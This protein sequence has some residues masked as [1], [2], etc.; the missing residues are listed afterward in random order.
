MKK[1]IYIITIAIVFTSCKKEQPK[2]EWPDDPMP[3]YEV[4]F[5]KPKNDAI[6]AF[7]KAVKE[8]NSIYHNKTEG[9]SA[10]LRSIVSGKKAGQY[11]WVE[12]PMSFEYVDNK[13]EIEGRM[14]SWNNNIMPHLDEMTDSNYLRVL[15]PLSYSKDG[16]TSPSKITNVTEYKIKKGWGNN[17][18][19][20]DI[21]NK[22]LQVDKVSNYPLS[23]TLLRPLAN[24]GE[25]IGYVFVS[26]HEN[27]ASFDNSFKDYNYNQEIDK[28]YGKE[29]RIRMWKT[30][31]ELQDNEG[32]W[33]SELVE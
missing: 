14:E 5:L 1:I 32:S 11:I 18:K 25:D 4:I 26:N 29:E 12:G 31:R 8:H 10:Y 15:T 13:K 33:V 6:E 16:N 7:Q 2:I 30:L 22:L 17:Q 3:I 21:N 9:V 20:W 19:V 28:V 27:W 23:Y 24:N